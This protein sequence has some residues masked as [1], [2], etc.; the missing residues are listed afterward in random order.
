[1]FGLFLFLLALVWCVLHLICVFCFVCFESY[2]R[3]IVASKCGEAATTTAGD[4]C[5][6]DPWTFYTAESMLI[7]TCITEATLSG[8]CTLP[9]IVIIISEYDDLCMSV[10]LVF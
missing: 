7:V 9:L 10:V 8:P 1:M 6:E 2:F 3:H 4:K 5:G